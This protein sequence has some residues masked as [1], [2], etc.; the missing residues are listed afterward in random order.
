MIKRAAVLLVGA[1]CFLGA[2]AVS[3]TPYDDCVKNLAKTKVDNM[4][5]DD[6]H[7][8]C[9]KQESARLLAEVQKVYTQIAN[10]KAYSSWNKGNGMF[11]GRV[12]DTYNAWLVTLASSPVALADTTKPT[13][14]LPLNALA[15][16]FKPSAKLEPSAVLM[17]TRPVLA[18]N[19]TPG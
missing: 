13:F 19:E 16:P 10:D 1:G 6:D 18:A 2:A 7:A 3:A 11:K 9:L 14:I 4:L 17:P 5:S 8:I 15:L 12:R